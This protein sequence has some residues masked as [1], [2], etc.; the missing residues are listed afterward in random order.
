MS[1]GGL[2]KTAEKKLRKPATVKAQVLF[3]ARVLGDRRTALRRYQ[4]H[5][6][7]F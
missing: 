1:S 2:L 4:L 6:I 7:I 3:R 5:E